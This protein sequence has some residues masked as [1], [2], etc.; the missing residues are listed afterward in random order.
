MN[1]KIVL[2]VEAVDGPTERRTFDKS[3]VTV[4]RAPDN[5]IQV[6][7]RHRPGVHHAAWANCSRRHGMLE[8]S[9]E[10][11]VLHDTG[12]A[13]GWHCVND[14]IVAPHRGTCTLKVGDRYYV[15]DTRIT[16]IAFE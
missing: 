5:D 7:E 6:T 13:N 14:D 16:I 1:H 15:G 11:L 8:V 3:K 4:G 12:T 10:A 9:G 2:D